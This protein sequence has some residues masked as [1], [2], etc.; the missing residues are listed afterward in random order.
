MIIFQHA[1]DLQRHLNSRKKE[2]KSVG[3]VPTMGAL[4]VGHM[5]LI[6]RAQA[7][8]DI[9]VA[10]I[11]VNPT[12]FNEKS[13]L[14]KYPRPIEADIEMLHHQG[15]DV[16]YH[17][18]VTDIYPSNAEPEFEIDLGYL[19]EIMEGAFRPGHFKGVAQ[20]VD[21]LLNRV[22]PDQLFMG[23]KDYQQIAVVREMIKQKGHQTQLVMCPIIREPNGL[24]MSSRNRRLPPGIRSQA[25]LLYHT[26]LYAKSMKQIFHIADLEKRCFE[27]L[28]KPHFRPEYFNIV[29]G[30]TLK[31]VRTW[32]EAPT[33]VAC[34]AVWAGDVRLIDNMVL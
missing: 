33:V 16:L 29:D 3:F 23:Q 8:T 34:T 18:G 9:T 5:S 15:V 26:L 31:E 14:N 24:A 22:Q 11:F 6:E 28:N 12:Q 30:L 21:I 2:G 32:R 7:S 25:N 4:H 27:R 13:D 10:S 19:N 17:P 20:V 1:T